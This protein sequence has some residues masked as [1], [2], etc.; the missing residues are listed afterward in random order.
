MYS[1]FQGERKMLALNSPCVS[2]EINRQP[3]SIINFECRHCGQRFGSGTLK[4]TV[5]LYGIFFLAGKKS[6]YSGTTC[7]KCLNSVLFD[8][9]GRLDEFYNFFDLFEIPKDKTM[10]CDLK[11]YSPASCLAYQ[12]C[13]L[14]G[15]DTVAFRTLLSDFS[16]E[17]FHGEL[18][19]VMSDTPELEE[20]YFCSFIW[21]TSPPIGH[22]SSVYWYKEDDIK[23]LLSIENECK[24]KI[25]PRYYSNFDFYEA[26][27]K[28]CWEH[29][30]VEEYSE[31]TG[32]MDIVRH[33]KDFT[34]T[35]TLLEILV[36]DYNFSRISDSGIEILNM[37]NQTDTPF[38]GIG[39]TEDWS[40]ID[41]I[42]PKA[43]ASEKDRLKMIAEIEALSDRPYVHQYLNDNYFRFIH[44]Y[45]EL[46]AR[47]DFS[48]G[49]FRKLQMQYLTELYEFT[50]KES[51]ND[52]Q[53][54]FFPEGDTWTIIF[55][56]KALRGLSNIGFKYIHHLLKYPD[57]PID[58][59]DLNQTA[60]D[61]DLQ[62]NEDELRSGEGDSL[63]YSDN[64]SFNKKDNYEFNDKKTRSLIRKTKKSLENRLAV[65]DPEKDK[66]E[67]NEIKRQLAVI[68]KEMVNK[69]KN[70]NNRF[71]NEESIEV[72]T[73]CQGIRRA[74]LAILGEESDPYYD[75]RKKVYDHF[76]NSLKPIKSS[77][78]LYRSNIGIKWKLG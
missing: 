54:A 73:I 49:S 48:Y 60:F 9:S 4:I 41:F 58:T 31:I 40:D 61:P 78:Q 6:Q 5:F 51:L 70:Y 25:F 75:F 34:V 76:Y 13:L 7:P 56:G 77:T 59:I 71:P 72:G 10:V 63:Q 16:K 39:F 2:T 50:H 22:L 30:L 65:L 42:K 12:K 55:E 33:E 11:Y 68:E 15:F 32:T 18:S 29:Y 47:T 67:I 36:S 52:A 66:V 1:L 64:K 37:I 17:N 26:L 27:E 3:F 45:T 35:S 28:F 53:Y 8:I 20:E 23:T 14:D 24:I 44:D 74:L 21:N 43:A 62:Q 69:E 57:K 19:S 38:E 46:S